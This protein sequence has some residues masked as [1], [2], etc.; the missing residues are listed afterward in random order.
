MCVCVCAYA[1]H[2]L[3][4]MEYTHAQTHTDGLKML[5]GAQGGVVNPESSPPVRACKY[6]TR[7]RVGLTSL[8]ITGELGGRKKTKQV[9]QREKERLV[10]SN[11]PDCAQY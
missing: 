1:L 8:K 11:S 5:H 7:N 2:T 4:N 9:Q 10:A 3:I 6:I